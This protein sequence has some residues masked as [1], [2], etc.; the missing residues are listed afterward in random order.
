MSAGRY[1]R[2]TAIKRADATGE[3][4]GFGRLF[5]SNVRLRCVLWNPEI[6]T[7]TPCSAQPDLPLRLRKNLPLTPWDRSVYYVSEDPH[8]YIDYPFA[9]EESKI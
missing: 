8:G 6:L 1:S 3:L 9:E 5:I 4:I 2:E 7:P